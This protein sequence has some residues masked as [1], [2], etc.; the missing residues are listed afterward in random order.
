MLPGKQ[1]DING[2]WKKRW[3]LRRIQPASTLP[4]VPVDG[5]QL[6]LALP[7]RTP[8]SPCGAWIPPMEAAAQS[9]TPTSWLKI[10]IHR[11]II[12]CFVTWAEVYLIQ[13]D[14]V[15]GAA[16][17]VGGHFEFCCGIGNAV[18][19]ILH[20]E[21]DQGDVH[22]VR[23]LQRQFTTNIHTVQNTFFQHHVCRFDPGAPH[24]QSK[25]GADWLVI[26]DY[27]FHV[28]SVAVLS[29]F[30]PAGQPWHGATL[31]C[32]L[33][34]AGRCSGSQAPQNSISPSWFTLLSAGMWTQPQR[35]N[36][37]K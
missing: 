19:L 9:Q 25:D 12:V 20:Y 4:G 15:P 32:T 3:S 27:V 22:L 13:S 6:P 11:I 17:V 1:L 2:M 35:R 24:L 29:H 10:A 34:G 21:S 36:K 18:P 26:T 33:R 30:G 16:R 37:R 8:H 7:T 23:E 31:P 28:T 14:P 5:N